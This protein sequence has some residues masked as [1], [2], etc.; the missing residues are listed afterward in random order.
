[1]RW[2]ALFAALL[3]AGCAVREGATPAADANASAFA[4][5][6]G[7]VKFAYAKDEDLA[8][9][10]FPK[11]RLKIALL[12]YRG[13]VAKPREVMVEYARY[14]YRH[15]LKK[16]AIILADEALRQGRAEEAARLLESVDF[17][18]F[19]FADW[20]DYIALAAR[21]GEPQRSHL[22]AKIEKIAQ[23]N[24]KAAYEL[25]KFY[26]KKKLF[27]KAVP[28][29]EVAY[30]KG[31]N[32]EAGVRLGRLYLEMGE[33]RKGL[34]ILR[35]IAKKDDGK[36]ARIVARY[37][38]RKLQKELRRMNTPPISF[39]F[40]EPRE[41]FAK[42]M[43]I[44][45]YE[46][47]YMQKNVVPW[48]RLSYE[49]GNVDGM[50]DL[51]V[52]DIERDNLVRGKSYSGF[53]LQE[54]IKFLQSVKKKW[55]AKLIL[56]KI[57]ET[58]TQLGKSGE[59]KRIYEE[60]IKKDKVDAYWHL[61]QYARR[62]EPANTEKYLDYLVRI[63]F[64]P[65]MIEKAYLELL[66]Q[67]DIEKNHEILRYY[68]QAGHIVAMRYLAS[69][70]T[71]KIIP[72]VDPLEGCGLLYRLAMRDYPLRAKLDLKIA[73]CYLRIFP[74]RDIV[75]AA[76][77]MK[78]YADLGRPE[79]KYALARL[80]EDYFAD[81]PMVQKYLEEA[82]AEGY[83]EALLHYYTLV[84]KGE[85]DGDVQEAV[86]FLEEHLGHNPNHYLL[87]A[88]IYSEGY[89]VPIDLARAIK[90]Y[91]KA[92]E[93]GS[94]EAYY[95]LAKLYYDYDLEGEHKKEVIGLLRELIRKSA[96][97]TARRARYLLASYYY[98][99]DR[100]SEAKKVLLEV[101]RMRPDDPKARMMLYRLF[102]DPRYLYPK[103]RRPE[104][105]YGPL[106]LVQAQYLTERDP[107]RALYL[108]FKAMLCRT[109]EA[110]RVAYD[111]IRHHFTSP[112]SVYSIFARAKRSEPCFV[113][114]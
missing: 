45:K 46:E 53:D 11:A 6:G 1:M 41:F 33:E 110:E 31:R 83:R 57:Y 87:L 10:G 65:A 90:Y 106:L 62:F 13:Y 19:S 37:L 96:D 80:Y 56:A 22:F 50:L 73:S 98:K 66:E 8:R 113:D 14:A 60:Y 16:A 55:R 95:R 70:Y 47:L 89:P 108:A 32:I 64:V 74:Q 39:T 114:R 38:Y 61:Y 7:G 18:E 78:F 9:R 93:L 27:D 104:S 24:P 29:Y 112:K 75:K 52:L 30:K 58:Y 84:A 111:I 79:A 97:V 5:S 48:Y 86:R 35:R 54:A 103:G 59:A 67:K 82:K 21:L 17:E 44:K 25:A 88:Q 77:I 36:A 94:L 4:Y 68:A 43:R 100:F 92:M 51:I 81:Y 23:K 102:G 71:K 15:G 26:E 101:L 91:K 49:R 69:I 3:L 63:R 72:G 107:K 99:L 109:P 2:V 76:T 42:K 34:Y 85:I 40:K 12:I 20:R 28:F 105:N